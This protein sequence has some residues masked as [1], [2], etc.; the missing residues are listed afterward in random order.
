MGAEV[1]EPEEV[2]IGDY[3]MQRVTITFSLCRHMDIM[4]IKVISQFK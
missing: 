2:T 4:L 3:D 1:S